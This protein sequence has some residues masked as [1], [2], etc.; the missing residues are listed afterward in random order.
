MSYKQGIN[1]NQVILLPKTVEE[2]VTDN[3]QVRFIEVFV[4]NL[5][6]QE[7][8]FSYAGR[9]NNKLKGQPAYSPA[10]M[11]KLYVYGYLNKIRSSRNLEKEC[12]K[13]LELIWLMRNLTPDFKT[14]ADFR[15]N[16]TAGIRK[17]FKE[18]VILCKNLDLFGGELVAIDGSK[19]KAVNSRKRNFNR[20]KIEKM[21]VELDEAIE[22]YMK[23]LEENDKKEA[24]IKIPAVK[25]LKRKIEKLKN[26]KEYLKQLDNQIEESHETQI[27]LTDPDAR[28]MKD[29]QKMDV[30]YNVQVTI[31]AKH[32]LMLDYEATN[33]TDDH[34]MLAEMSKKAKK[35]LEVKKIEVLADTGYYNQDLIKESIDNGITPYVPE[36]RDKVRKD[37]VPA[38]EYSVSKFK[39]DDKKDVYVCLCQKELTYRG[40]STFKGRVLLLYRTKACNGCSKRDKCTKNKQGRV[41][42]RW[43]HEEILEKM[44][45]RLKEEK[46]KYKSRQQLCEHPFG[47]IKRTF[48]QGYM[49]M[50]G[51]QKTNAEF[52]LTGLAYNIKR[53]INI[54]GGVQNLIAAMG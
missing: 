4:E 41:I 21:L 38:A 2:Y 15:K 35:I 7:L 53:V 1:R 13:N 25:D 42:Y 45:K 30:C 48:N 33:E 22:K 9:E 49:L 14:I 34:F 26:K 10:D 32:K 44:R 31:D 43:E 23:E 47:T 27:S 19:F 24:K 46:I 36:P 51:L 50:K 18:F 17:V 37:G 12:Q 40:R 52:G 16:N 6:L 3:N 29:G 20:K 8:G 11:L 5:H 54:M 39:Y 28:L